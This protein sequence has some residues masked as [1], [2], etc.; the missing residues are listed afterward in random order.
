M[1]MK[2]RKNNPERSDNQ[3]QD[4]T[5]QERASQEEIL[6]LDELNQEALYLCK[7]SRKDIGQHSKC[8]TCTNFEE[9]CRYGNR[10]WSNIIKAYG[11]ECRDYPDHRC[12]FAPE[13][14]H[15]LDY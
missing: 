7:L 6:N 1:I 10:C 5:S 3:L 9:C 8:H 12:I 13:M 15:K 2:T 14:T 4:G 11:K